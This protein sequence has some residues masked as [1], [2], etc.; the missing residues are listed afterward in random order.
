MTV[1]VG[2]HVVELKIIILSIVRYS[3]IICDQTFPT[4]AHHRLST[5]SQVNFMNRKII[6]EQ[7]LSSVLT[8]GLV[9]SISLFSMLSNLSNSTGEHQIYN[10]QHIS[11]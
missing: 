4:L 8:P 1:D 5:T 2:L 7:E 10:F 9:D 6:E 3:E 11:H